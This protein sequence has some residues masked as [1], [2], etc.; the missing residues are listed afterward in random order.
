MKQSKNTVALYVDKDLVNIYKASL[1]LYEAS[2]WALEDHRDGRV[3][4]PVS[5]HTQLLKALAKA[6]IKNEVS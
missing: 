2:K 4:L 6:E 3:K 1:D 5:T